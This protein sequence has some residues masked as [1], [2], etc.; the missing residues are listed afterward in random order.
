M[1]PTD[2]LGLAREAAEDA[3]LRSI[4]DLTAG[5]RDGLLFVLRMLAA[6]LHL[7]REYSPLAA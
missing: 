7:E 5:Q 6:P 2:L 1:S 3:R 4:D